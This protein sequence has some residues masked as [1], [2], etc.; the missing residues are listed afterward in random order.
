MTCY[1]KTTVVRGRLA[2]PM[3]NSSISLFNTYSN[4]MSGDSQRIMLYHDIHYVDVEHKIE[5]S[6]YF[7]NNDNF[8]KY[9]QYNDIE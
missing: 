1:G 9:C 5:V 2:A 3:Q 7:L 8:I 6:M 4:C